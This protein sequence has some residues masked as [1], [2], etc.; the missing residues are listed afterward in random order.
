LPR[1]DPTHLDEALDANLHDVNDKLTDHKSLAASLTGGFLG[2]LRFILG[3]GVQLNLLRPVVLRH[4]KLLL[5]I[6]SHLDDE[7]LVEVVGVS[8]E[9]DA[10]RQAL[11][12]ALDLFAPAGA[13]P[14]VTGLIIEF[15]LIICGRLCLR[16]S[17]SWV[18]LATSMR[19]F[20]ITVACRLLV[21]RA[22]NRVSH[23]RCSLAWLALVRVEDVHRVEIRFCFY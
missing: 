6:L 17:T 22:L 5:P 3:V 14:Q 2:K 10:L 11:E 18:R 9:G 20:V 13:S 19:I 7:L 23:F 8:N 16:V 12:K 4:V 1:E 15:F 21:F